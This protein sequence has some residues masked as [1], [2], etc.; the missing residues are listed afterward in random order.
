MNE[1]EHKQMKKEISD[2]FCNFYNELIKIIS[3]YAQVNDGESCIDSKISI[4]LIS[5]HC[6]LFQV[7]YKENK[8]H[9]VLMVVDLLNLEIMHNKGILKHGTKTP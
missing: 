2:H 9:T 8:L 5:N 4:A 6:T 7:L 1:K 3:M